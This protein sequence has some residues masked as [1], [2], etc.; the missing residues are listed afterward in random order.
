M[1]EE[2]QHAAEADR[3]GSIADLP[4]YRTLLKERSRWTWILTAIMLAVYFGYILLVAFNRD[5]LAQPIG[6]GVTTLGI[7][8]GIGVI[9]VGIGLTGV[10]VHRANRRFDALEEAV[11]REAGE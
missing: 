10:Y 3:W 9:L 11:R 8:L 6:D 5:F 2:R 4:D 1:G 7:P